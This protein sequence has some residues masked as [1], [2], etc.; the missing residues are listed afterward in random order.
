MEV[1][2]GRAGRDP[3]QIAQISA[4]MQEQPYSPQRRPIGVTLA[5]AFY[6]FGFTACAIAV[7]TLVYSGSVLDGA[8]RLNP[9]ARAGFRTI[10]T[11]PSVLLL[12]TVA[13]ACAAASYGLAKRRRW[14]RRLAIGI[15]V[16]NLIGDSANAAVRRDPRTLLGLPIGGAM[17][18]YL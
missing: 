5:A 16:V 7:L 1:E 9:E 4:E 18:V 11:L 8:W 13:T 10:G 3:A 6:A 14:G 2:R 15:L 17:I 12:S